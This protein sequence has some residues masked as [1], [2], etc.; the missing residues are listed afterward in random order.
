[1]PGVPWER[2]GQFFSSF[3]L[4]HLSWP[5]HTLVDNVAR[6]LCQRIVQRW[7]SKDSKPVRAA[8]EAHVQEQWLQRE[9]G[10][11]AFIHRLQ[12]EL[13]KELGGPVESLFASV[14]ES[15]KAGS[16]QGE[17]RRRGEGRSVSRDQ[18]GGVLA[19]LEDLVGRPQDEG[20]LP[21]T[22]PKLLGMLRTAGDR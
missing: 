4:F 8:V 21:E 22:P 9:L 16:N 13:I 17:G 3:G 18:L 1:L 10:A 6:R 12:T 7:L 11:D 15:L 19:E 5:R 14:V 2:R 20:P